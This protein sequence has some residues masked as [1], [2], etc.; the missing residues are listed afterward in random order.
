[1]IPD[2]QESVQDTIKLHMV[3]V[4]YTPEHGIFPL[5]GEVP[6]RGSISTKCC[7][8]ILCK[9]EASTSTALFAHA[10]LHRKHAGLFPTS[11]PRLIA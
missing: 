4:T 2:A 5:D 1:M 9:K 6:T 10:P 7:L 8:E 3:T 11:Q